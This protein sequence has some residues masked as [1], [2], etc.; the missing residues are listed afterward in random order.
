VATYTSAYRVLDVATLLPVTAATAAL[1]LLRAQRSKQSL[2]AFVSQYL[3]LAIVLGLLIA[4]VL[5]SAARPTLAALYSDRYDSAA[6]TLVALAWVAGMTLITNVF[7]P[8]AVALNKRRLMLIVSGAALLA[9]LALNL[10]LIH[11]L[12]ALGA[13]LATFAT[14]V[15]VTAPLAWACAREVAVRPRMRPVIAALVATAAWLAAQLFFGQALGQG[16]LLALELTVV[17]LAVFGLLAPAWVMAVARSLRM[18]S[19][20][21]QVGGDAAPTPGDAEPTREE[22]VVVGAGEGHI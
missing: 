17:W 20:R 10:P 13:A 15:V 5:T 19:Q 12:G 7:S 2:S 3:E 22:P 8:L 11:F 6:P 21:I 18:G 4:V 14:E 16:W 1:P 9:N